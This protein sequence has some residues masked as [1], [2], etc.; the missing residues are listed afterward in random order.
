MILS[1]G[2]F[3]TL[4]SRNRVRVESFLSEGGEA[5]VYEVTEVKTGRKCAW[6][7]FKN[8]SA[9]RIKRTRFLVD[10]KLGE[11]SEY[12][13]APFDW[14]NN[15][16]VGHLSKFAPGIS[17]EEHL[18]TP[19]NSFFSNFTI[20]IALCHT[21]D[22]LNK[23][24][25]AHG[26]IHL[27]NFKIARAGAQPE[28]YLLDFDNFNS[29]GVPS[30]LAIGQDHYMAP[31]LRLA[32]KTGQPAIPDECS[33]RFSLTAVLYD[34]IMAKHVGSGFDNDPDEFDEAMLSGRWLH[35]PSMG[36]GSARRGDGYPSL[37]LNADL[38]RMIRRGL[39]LDRQV[40]PPAYEW[41]AV[42]GQAL[43]QIYVHPPCGGPVFIDSSKTRCPYCN[44]PYPVLKLV[45]PSLHKEIVCDSGSVPL[46]RTQLHSPKV[47][48][49]HA[50]LRRFGPE[51]RLEPL[52][53]NGTFRLA[54]TD[55]AKLAQEVPIQTGDRLRFA[56]VDCYVV[57]ALN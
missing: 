26:D 30:P 44:R 20:A 18:E 6:K 19:G 8:S 41:R 29:P 9:D 31:E 34:I 24:N 3:L 38:A 53:S 23:E 7:A 22:L 11:V 43:L 13:C 1:K 33:D 37:M 16:S 48:A 51:T 27:N 54:G 32:L 49:L 50:V 39:S 12:F 4:P 55:W 46:G 57:E 17:L 35:D 15:G 56:D 42:L 45:F 28:L 40:R 21:I 5:Q 10:R 14:L 47:S 25:I 52:G 2:K 36:D